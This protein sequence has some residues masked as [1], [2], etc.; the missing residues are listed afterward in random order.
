MVPPK[1]LMT[2]SKPTP[3]YDNFLDLDRSRLTVIS[4]S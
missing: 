2:F 3:F 4:L 1:K